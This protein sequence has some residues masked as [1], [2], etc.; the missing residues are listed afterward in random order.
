MSKSKRS[1]SGT[2]SAPEVT[3]D[4][5]VAV[6][7]SPVVEQDSVID[8]AEDTDSDV[9]SLSDAEAADTSEL[10]TESTEIMR[11]GQDGPATAPAVAPEPQAS[12]VIRPAPVD[13]RTGVPVADQ[14][15]TN[16]KYPAADSTPEAPKF[17]EEKAADMNRL[18]IAHFLEDMKGCVTLNIPFEFTKHSAWQVPKWFAIQYPNKIVIRG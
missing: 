5:N 15:P 4:T 11:D 14:F 8:D 18:V 7:D 3:E 1:L 13:A 16:T 9:M 10:D 6:E 12:P 17:D 2:D